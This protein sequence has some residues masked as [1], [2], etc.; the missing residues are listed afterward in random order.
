[1]FSV[2][3]TEVVFDKLRMTRFEV[4]RLL[5]RPPEPVEGR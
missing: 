4:W 3:K 5:T 1:M 2:I